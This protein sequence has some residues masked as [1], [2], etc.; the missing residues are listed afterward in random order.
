MPATQPRG[1][2][3]LLDS[4]ATSSARDDPASGLAQPPRCLPRCWPAKPFAY[5]EHDCARFAAGAVEAVTGADPSAGLGIR[6]TTLAG[7]R[8]ALVARGYRDPVAFVREHFAEIPVAQAR[9]GDLAVVHTSEGPALSVVGGAVVFAPA[10][11][12]GLGRCRSPLL[13]PHSG[14]RPCIKGCSF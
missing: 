4:P 5:G 12:R 11:D 10:P 2:L 3:C 1:E 9:M 8:R 7:G 6:Y 14:S 13:A